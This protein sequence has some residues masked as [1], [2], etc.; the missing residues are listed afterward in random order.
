MMGVLTN[1]FRRKQKI[2]KREKLFEDVFF[3]PGYAYYEH[4]DDS[5]K[6]EMYQVFTLYPSLYDENSDE[7][8][9]KLC[10]DIVSEV[11]KNKKVILSVKDTEVSPN[12]LC[13]HILELR[14]AN[15]KK[16]AVI[17]EGKD[18]VLIVCDVDTMI[19]HFQQFEDNFSA[20]C[21]YELY[22]CK[23][24]TELLDQAQIEHTL[25]ENNFDLYF[26]YSKYPDYLEIKLKNDVR[27]NNI[28]EMIG[29]ACERNQRRL[30][31]EYVP[32][33]NKE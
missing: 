27:V 29:K 26:Y 31:V 3:S 33:C 16:Q 4:E 24:E 17:F 12:V 6:G 21:I 14:K 19:F 8:F 28:I 23:K 1:L 7:D 13:H 5:I 25:S 22:G 18:R 2:E 32:L 10:D 9:C 30:F 20:T 15:Q 11:L